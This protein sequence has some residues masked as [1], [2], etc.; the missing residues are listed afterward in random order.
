M[1]K[2]WL[3]LLIALVV[4]PVFAGTIVIRKS[5]FP[6]GGTGF[7]FNESVTS[8]SFL[9][10]DGGSQTFV[11]VTAGTYTVTEADPAVTPGGWTLAD[12]SCDDSDSVGDVAARTATV[13]VGASE[14]VTCTFRNLETAPTDNLFV[15]HLDGAQEVPPVPTTSRGG[16]MGRFDAGASQLSFVCT[17]D[18]AGAIAMHVH[19]GAPGVNGPILFDFGAPVSPVVAT[20]SGMTP[21][22]VADLVAGNFYVNIHTAAFPGGFVRGQ[23]LTRTV[24]TVAFPLSGG[25]VAPPSGSASTGNCT[26]DLDAPATAL[27]VNCTHNVP[28]PTAAHL[29]DAP[30]GTNG[31][32]VFTFPSAASPIATNVPMTPRFVAD[33]AAGFLYVD[34]HAG[35]GP[36]IRGQVG[37]VS[38][39]VALTK[40]GPASITAGTNITYT[41]TVSNAGPANAESVTL[42]D[43]V[44]AGTAFVSLVQNTGPAFTCDTSVVCNIAALASGATAT[45]T[46]VVSTSPSATLP[47]TNTASIATM[48]TDPDSSNDS[49]SVITT[50]TPPSTDLGVTK[51]AG[52]GPFVTGGAAQFTITVSNLSSM[53]ATGATVTDT[54]PAGM[55]LVSATPSQGSCSGTTTVTCTLG[56]IAAAG[57]AT[58][59][60][61]VTLPSA[62][63]PLTNMA[64]VSM[65]T[66]D[67]NPANNSD[68]AS[69][70]VDAVGAIPMVSPLVLALL[71]LTMAAIAL[72]KP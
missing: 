5:T 58:I 22:D 10:N 55:T 29:H 14:T 40:T 65:A 24:D 51:S 43:V 69:I 70:T 23:I 17:H 46:L 64:T 15:F 57:S 28:A 56:T 16:C 26:A 7:S 35:A 42:T 38:A 2:R 60:L 6:A 53:A 49:S 59:V 11:S 41:L 31:P 63:G 1:Q 62:A 72:T 21:A 27:A 8:G 12:L 61:N 3:V 45:F 30:A 54:L 4:S 68:S 25:Q 13:N 34:V 71:A 20:W 52:A 67:T 39:D 32:I 19:R 44:P 66:I 18:V 50:L 48:S 33:F 36:V 47:V 37:S 9:L